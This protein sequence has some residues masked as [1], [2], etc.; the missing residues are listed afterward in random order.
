MTEG[1]AMWMGALGSYESNFN[2]AERL[3]LVSG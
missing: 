3:L 2:R 1:I